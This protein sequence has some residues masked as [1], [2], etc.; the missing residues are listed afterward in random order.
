M[1]YGDFVSLVLLA[2]LFTWASS[3]FAD[4]ANDW[5]QRR[6]ALLKQA[7]EELSK[8]L[9]EKASP[10]Q[11]AKANG[12]PYPVPTPKMNKLIVRTDALRQGQEFA[13]KEYSNQR[14]EEEILKV[15][16]QYSLLKLEDMVEVELT[17]KQGT[18][19]SGKLKMFNKK[20]AKIGNN[21]VNL[22]DLPQDFKDRLASDT[23]DALQERK[24]ADARRSF[25]ARKA[26]C[27]ED[28]FAELL[29]KMLHDNGYYPITGME[30]DHGFLE[31]DNWK[32]M[33]DVFDEKLAKARGEIEDELREEIMNRIM[34]GN[35]FVYNAIAGE[36]I[37]EGA[38]DGKTDRPG[39][40]QKIKKL[41][42]D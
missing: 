2:V 16:Q 6:D 9:D 1:K 28:K 15:I 32:S 3:I 20:F 35:G 38:K 18:L 5:R 31:L 24:V 29:P 41:F 10:L 11:I 7:E 4:D 13:E 12:M 8:A 25:K 40:F 30:G 37:P 33:K 26:K 19:V 27:A 42:G 36:W 39:F 21:W 14:E 17:T 22:A 34:K 23:C